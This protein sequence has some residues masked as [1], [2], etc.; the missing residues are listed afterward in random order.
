[1]W[2]L[3]GLVVFGAAERSPEAAEAARLRIRNGHHLTVTLGKTR[4]EAFGVRPDKKVWELELAA[5][6]IGAVADLQDVTPNAR[7]ERWSI[8]VESARLALDPTRF[9]PSHVY[10]LEIRRA[11]L[12]VGTAFVYLYPPP[13]ERVRRVELDDRADAPDRV[14][15]PSELGVIPKSGL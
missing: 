8:P 12:V 3:V 15:G 5:E 10:R 6:L 13:A 9:L 7:G 11:R 2:C 14:D 1:M 4:Q